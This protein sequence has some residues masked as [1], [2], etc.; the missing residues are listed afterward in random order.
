[1]D[2]LIHPTTTRAEVNRYRKR[3]ALSARNSAA[4]GVN[5]HAAG[6]DDGRDVQGRARI[7]INLF[8]ETR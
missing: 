8:I 2:A 6:I 5:L 1:M 3:E 4:K 7:P